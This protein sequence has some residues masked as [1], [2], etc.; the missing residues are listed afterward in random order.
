MHPRVHKPK[1]LIHPAYNIGA[2]QQAR[3]PYDQAHQSNP[4]TY[5]HFVQVKQLMD[6]LVAAQ[7]NLQI[8]ETVPG[9]PHIALEAPV[10]G[11]H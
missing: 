8:E 5:T 1:T 2:V 6:A 4:F 10:E 3:L 7:G 11:R 9:S